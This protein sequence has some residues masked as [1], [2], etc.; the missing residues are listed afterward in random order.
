MGRVVKVEEL[1]VE[2]APLEPRVHVQGHYN[3]SKEAFLG[4]RFFRSCLLRFNLTFFPWILSLNF[5]G[6]CLPFWDL[7]FNFLHRIELLTFNFMRGADSDP[8]RQLA[9]P[10]VQTH[11]W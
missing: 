2:W 1:G 3:S 6:E 4:W 7:S 9:Q 10:Q 5:L 8:I 11:G